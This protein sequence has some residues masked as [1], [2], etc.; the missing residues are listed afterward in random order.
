VGFK[1]PVKDLCV[2]DMI[3][4]AFSDEAARYRPVRKNIRRT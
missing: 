4:Q 2:A 3:F 1:G